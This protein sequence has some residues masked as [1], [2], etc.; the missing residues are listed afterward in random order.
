MLFSN[1]LILT[2]YMHSRG[3]LLHTYTH[4]SGKLAFNEKADIDIRGMLDD[5]HCWEE[6][7]LDLDDLAPDADSTEEDSE[8]TYGKGYMGAARL[9][10]FSE[11]AWDE[12]FSEKAWDDDDDD[13]GA[14]VSEDGDAD[15]VKTGNHV[16][17]SSIPVQSTSSGFATAGT[18][19]T[20]PYP[21]GVATAA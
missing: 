1:L 17:H 2:L 15:D 19:V 8:S 9:R 5:F 10:S 20:P 14:V 6:R 16:Y 11:K 4:R 3:H 12:S 13:L 18:P 21:S 7:S